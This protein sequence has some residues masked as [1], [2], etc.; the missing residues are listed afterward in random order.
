MKKKLIYSS[1][2][3]TNSGKTSCMKYLSTKYKDILYIPEIYLEQE[4]NNHKAMREKICSGRIN[5]I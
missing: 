1:R 5:K 3:S 2:R 4:H